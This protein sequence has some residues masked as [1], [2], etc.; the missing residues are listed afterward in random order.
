VAGAERDI[1]SRAARGRGLSQKG[2][3]SG[4]N[5]TVL[6]FGGKPVPTSQTGTGKEEVEKISGE[7]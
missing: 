1:A 3:A 2:P 7:G 5:Q 4:A 6:F